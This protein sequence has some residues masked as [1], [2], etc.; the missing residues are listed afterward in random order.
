[1]LALTASI[2]AAQSASPRNGRDA[3]FALEQQGKFD[4]AEDRVALDRSRRSPPMPKHTLIWA[5]LKRARNT[6][7]RPF[8]FTEKRWRS[9]PPCPA[10]AL[11]LGLAL[12][13]GGELKE[14]IQIV[15]SAAQERASILSRR[16]ASDR[17]GRHC[18]L[19]HRRI[20]GGDS[21]SRSRRSQRSA[22]S[23][24][25]ASAGAQ[26]SFSRQFQCVLDT[27][28]EILTLNAESAEADM[29]AGEAEDEM[30]NH[31]R[32]HRAVSRCGQGRSQGA[33]RALRPGLP[34]YGRK[35]NSKKPR[36]QF[37]AELANVPDNAA[38][39]RIPGRLRHAVE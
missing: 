18:R 38:G 4:E 23:A 6:T 39:P 26:L 13:K 15:R 1:M 12:F 5:F 24:V 37:Q 22:E 11:N 29:L 9:I 30:H 32:R 8:R 19:R 25:S 17:V 3:A 21:L 31:S 27:Y 14:A 2:V 34:V 36:E 7:S 20:R 28:H 35:I 33:Q 10:C 16:A